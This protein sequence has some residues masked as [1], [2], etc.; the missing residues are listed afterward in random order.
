AC[1][2]CDHHIPVFKEGGGKAAADHLG[3][4]FLGKIPL[5]PEVVIGGDDGAPSIL[6]EGKFKESF[7]Q[8][9][10]KVAKVLNIKSSN[11]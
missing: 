2:N 5:D 9:A 7:G 6:E 8:I 11:D 10:E 1:P 3:L 4:V